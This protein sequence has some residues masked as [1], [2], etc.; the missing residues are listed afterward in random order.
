MPSI[1]SRRLELTADKL[2]EA[3]TY[4]TKTGI[5]RWKVD[6]LPVRK[7]AIAGA[8]MESGYIQIRLNRRLYR[9]HRLAW[10]YVYGQWPDGDL[11]HKD[12]IRHHNWINNLRI[13]T[14]A[15]NHGNAPRSLANT[16]GF[17]GVSFH[18]KGKKWRAVIRHN[19]RS[20]HIGLF[21]TREAAH[22]AYVAR[23]K[24]LFGEFANPG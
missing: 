21:D 19:Y 20:N 1:K 23:A 6:R 12:T 24:E 11:D 15:Q 13:A 16:S 7:G 17:K 14:N 22:E 3:L 2:R 5:F 10:L 9:A 4:D 18:K 8:V